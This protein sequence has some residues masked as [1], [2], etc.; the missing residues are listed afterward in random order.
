MFLAYGSLTIFF[1]LFAIQILAS[2]K[3]FVTI[4]ST[5]LAFPNN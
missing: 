2:T 4:N 5:N 1:D 3:S